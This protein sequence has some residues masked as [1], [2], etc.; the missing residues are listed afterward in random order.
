MESGKPEIKAR[1]K[2]LTFYCSVCGEFKYQFREV[3][4][5]VIVCT[6][7]AAGNMGGSAVHP[8]YR[9]YLEPLNPSEESEESEQAQS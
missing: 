6:E 1:V 5:G 8:W 3:K 7:C 9:E 4:K 2:G